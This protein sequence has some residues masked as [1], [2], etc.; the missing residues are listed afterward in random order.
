MKNF[1]TDYEKLTDVSWNLTTV[2]RNKTQRFTKKEVQNIITFDIETSNGF[3][4]PDGTTIGFSHDLYKKNPEIYV[5]STPVSLMYVWQTAVETGND[6]FVFMGRTWA[7]YK[8][9]LEILSEVVL[10]VSSGINVA[11]MPRPIRQTLTKSLKKSITRPL[12]NSCTF[13]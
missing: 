9:F 3:R 7:E 2:K 12:K 13:V 4:Q 10:C 6:I 11:G 8:L 1:F 5:K